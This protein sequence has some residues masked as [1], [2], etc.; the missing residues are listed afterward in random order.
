MGYVLFEFYCG[1]SLGGVALSE[2]S[3]QDMHNQ[4]SLLD[5]K[6][7]TFISKQ[8]AHQFECDVES[9]LTLR[10]SQAFIC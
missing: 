10:K 1:Y 7:H 4:L 9:V 6:N 8:V 2:M 3:S 5:D